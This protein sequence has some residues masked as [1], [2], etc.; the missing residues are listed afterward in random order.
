MSPTA[1]CAVPVNSTHDLGCFQPYGKLT[2]FVTW[3]S[4]DQCSAGLERTLL[5]PLI[6]AVK[7]SW[8]YKGSHG[9][10]RQQQLTRPRRKLKPR[11]RLTTGQARRLAHGEGFPDLP[12]LARQERTIQQGDS[13]FCPSLVFSPCVATICFEVDNMSRMNLC[14]QHYGLEK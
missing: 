5:T 3:T 9:L 1:L 6:L 7:S 2:G 12:L 4:S 8:L 10:K 14:S 11:Q 13:Q